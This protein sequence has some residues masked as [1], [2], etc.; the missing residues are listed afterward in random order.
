MI[1]TYIARGGGGARATTR[2]RDDVDI[3]RVVRLQ[4]AV[5]QVDFIQL[6]ELTV[7]VVVAGV[8]HPAAE[9]ETPAV[10]PLG[11]L[12]EL[13]TFPQVPSIH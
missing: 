6:R 3:S 13:L 7:G 8:S 9:G 10:E 2:R 1:F 5:S 12:A 11:C 4:V